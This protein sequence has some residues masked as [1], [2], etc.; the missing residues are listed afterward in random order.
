MSRAETI[1]AAPSG[2][3][4]VCSAPQKEIDIFL[5]KLNLGQS[6]LQLAAAEKRAK[7]QKNNVAFSYALA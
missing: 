5:L 3:C 7:R 4:P 6:L 2:A 1:R